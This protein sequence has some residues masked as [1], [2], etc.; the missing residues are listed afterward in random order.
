MPRL[1]IPQVLKAGDPDLAAQKFLSLTEGDAG[2]VPIDPREDPIC[3]FLR[4]HLSDDGALYGDVRWLMDWLISTARK[5]DELR[6]WLSERG[7]GID[8][9]LRWPVTAL[10]GEV[11]LLRE[12]MGQIVSSG[13][14]SI[15]RTIQK[16]TDEKGGRPI[17]ALRRSFALSAAWLWR[18]SNRP[19]LTAGMA[20]VLACA[21]GIERPEGDTT[22]SW[23][24]RMNR[25]RSC[26]PLRPGDPPTAETMLI[27]MLLDSVSGTRRRPSSLLET[28]YSGRWLR[29]AGRS[30]SS[31]SPRRR[32]ASNWPRL[33]PGCTPEDPGRVW[34]R[35][36]KNVLG[37]RGIASGHRTL[38]GGDAPDPG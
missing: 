29:S 8:P 24:T 22:R 36:G 13:W 33:G 5:Q 34:G 10:Y 12:T 35:P 11:Q 21:L 19:K 18:A 26:L 30:E 7:D 32:R 1:T 27:Y 6:E 4:E 14:I 2:G 28:L 16:D 3:L 17:L 37:F 25:A 23:G 15:V 9:R 38:H 20:A 31:Q